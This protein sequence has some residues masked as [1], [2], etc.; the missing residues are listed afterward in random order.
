MYLLASGSIPR[1]PG[2]DLRYSKHGLS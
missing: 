1:S 2:A